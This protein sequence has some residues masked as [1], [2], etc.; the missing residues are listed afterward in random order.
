MQDFDAVIVGAGSTGSAAAFHLAG[1][2]LRVA[3]VE[4][5]SLGQAGARW[6]DD[7]SPWMFDRAGVARPEP[8]E[9]RCDLVPV[10]FVSPSGT[11]RL[12]V[13]SRPMW[14]VDLRLLVERLQRAA[15]DCGVVTFDRARLDGLALVDG[16]PAVLALTDADQ[17]SVQLRARLFVDA[18]GMA[19]AL[20]RR[21]PRAA[22]RWPAL[23]SV[24]VCSAAQQVRGVI[25]RAGAAAFLERSGIPAGHVLTQIGLCG[26]F[27]TLAITVEPS[28]EA[29]EILTGVT[30]DGAHGTGPSLLADFVRTQPWIGPVVFGGAGRIPIR[31]PYDRLGVPGLALLGD[32]G[33]QSFPAHGSGV[34]SGLIAAKI[35]AESVTGGGDPGGL[36]ATWRYQAAF[37]RERGGVHAAYELVRR[38]SQSLSRPGIEALFVGGLI[39]PAGSLA[40]LDQ[41]LHDRSPTELVALARSALRAPLPAAQMLRRVLRMPLVRALYD[42]Y[43]ARP[44]ER[45]LRVWSRLAAILVGAPVE[46]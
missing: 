29:V 5:R 38:A 1:A 27:S 9:K 8:P 22:R 36:E 24:E 15:R 2:G 23:R 11:S 45:A 42:R 28:M 14:G 25:D 46:G 10:T 18:S 39:E 41:R 4:A 30:D 34:G 35:L 7:I 40:A 13:G 3:L 21:M 17:T 16:R 12:R 37:H 43:P 33:C 26:G 32:A 19:Q 31:R 20:I 44:D 6:V